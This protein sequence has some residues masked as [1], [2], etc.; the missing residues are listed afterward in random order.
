MLEIAVFL[1]GA[2]VMVI[3]LTG[4]RVLAPYLGTSLV[5]WT[6]LIGI[7]LASLSVGYWWGG[8]LAD[9]RPE[10]RVLGGIILVSA[11]AT[12]FVALIKT[13]VLG[14]LQAKNGGLH[15]VAMSA[16]LILFAPPSILIGM[17]SPFAV[18]LK[19]ED[20]R[21]SG[22]TAG[23]LYA[24]STIGSISGTFLAG[25][26]LI[27][28][29]GST[30]ILLLM[31][32]VLALASLLV[33]RSHGRIKAIAFA[34]FLIIIFLVLGHD[35]RMASAGFVDVDTPY[36]RVLVVNGVEKNTGRSMRIMIT[37][38]HASQSAMYMD[39]PSEL[40][41]PY[42]RF[43]RLAKHFAPEM[44]RM[45]VLGG[46]GFSFPKY[47]L[48]NYVNVR[49]DVVELDPGITALARDHFAL[50]EH[51][52]LK[53]IEEDARTFLNRNAEKYE[54]ILCDTFNSHYAIPFHLTTLE[55]S[56]RIKASMSQNGVVLINLLSA[57]EGD[58]GRIF[59]AL[60]ATY[61]ITFPKVVAFAVDNPNDPSGWQNI[62]I[63]AFASEAEPPVLSSDRE[64]SAM[65]ANK[66][67]TPVALDMPALTD[68]FAPVDSYV[69]SAW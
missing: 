59:R 68:D 38:P 25:F 7:I 1:C 56:R 19:L 43:Y 46:G 34:I 58:R 45:L 9:R 65:L 13:L 55:A 35:K 62:I 2:V 16:T 50:R 32:A 30:N 10:A 61:A 6:S 31:A 48:E 22:R 14:F 44:G 52:R 21:T 18:R 24:I 23:K 41:M 29:L 20:M 54:V 49:V 40:A 11:F 47:A 28:G 37:G 5:V 3:E 33:E 66:I 64:I 63:A 69:S 27:P 39:D 53:I 8:R 67:K 4:S 17:V 42:T 57:I 36:N 12:A 15:T 60:F 26:V 51:P